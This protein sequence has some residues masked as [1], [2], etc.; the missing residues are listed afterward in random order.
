MRWTFDF[1]VTS[2]VSNLI[3]IAPMDL[4]LPL[5]KAELLER[6]ASSCRET[7]SAYRGIGHSLFCTFPNGT[8][9]FSSFILARI[10]DEVCSVESRY[11][12]GCH[13]PRLSHRQRHVWLEA[14]GV[15]LDITHDQFADTGMAGWVFPLDNAWHRKFQQQCRKAP[16]Y[17]GY[18]Q[19]Q[20]DA[21]CDAAIEAAR[22]CVGH[23]WQTFHFDNDRP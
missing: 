8:C 22:A 7:L 21:E 1:G 16:E 13:H 9:D 18:D 17:P 15:V 23:R 2:I 10:L 3:S 12:V 19:L 5:G 6:I 4:P 20:L 14:E 11:V